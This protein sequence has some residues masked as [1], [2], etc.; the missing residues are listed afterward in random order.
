MLVLKDMKIVMTGVDEAGKEYK[1]EFAHPTGNS[2]VSWDR[3]VQ[4][5]TEWGADGRAIGRWVFGS[6]M[7]IH[8]SNNHAPVL[9]E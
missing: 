8:V 4:H 6:H 5:S 2:I 3:N 9:T 7:N 1:Q